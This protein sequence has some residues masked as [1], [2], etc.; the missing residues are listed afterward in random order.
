MSERRLSALLRSMPIPEEQQAEERAWE[1]VRAAHARAARTPSKKLF[2]GFGRRRS[3]RSSAR[4][5]AR[6]A[7]WAM[8]SAAAASWTTRYAAR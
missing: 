1:L 6:K 7:S 4:T 8:S 5:A 3:K 2:Q